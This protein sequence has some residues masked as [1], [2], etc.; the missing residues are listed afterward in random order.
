MLILIFLLF[1]VVMGCN[2]LPP[3]KCDEGWTPVRRILGGWCARIGEL[4]ILGGEE[5][6]DMNG[7]LSGVESNNE[8][9]IYMSMLRESNITSAYVGGFVKLDECLCEGKLCNITETC[10]IPSVWSWNDEFVVGTEM[11]NTLT[12]QFV[13]ENKYAA[14]IAVSTENN[15]GLI[16]SLDTTSITL[17]YF[18]CGKKSN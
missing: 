1:G 18:F 8:L 5:C 15:I 12:P 17:S 6:S 3:I 7:N 14:N 13:S 4:T 11:L 9:N 10:Q 16:D 2:V